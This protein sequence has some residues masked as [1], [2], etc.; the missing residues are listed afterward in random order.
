MGI[1]DDGIGK[2]SFATFRVEARSHKHHL[3]PDIDG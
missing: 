2:Q 1:Y 3:H